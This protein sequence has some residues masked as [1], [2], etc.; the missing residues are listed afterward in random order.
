MVPFVL[1]GLKHTTHSHS[2]RS[3]LFLKGLYLFLNLILSSSCV[4]HQLRL[5]I[6]AVSRPLHRHSDAREF[7]RSEEKKLRRHHSGEASC[8]QY[9]ARA[10]DFLLLLTLHTFHS[11]CIVIGFVT[12]E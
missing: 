4:A 5:L 8:N 6:G 7:D 12:N 2:S 3:N 9:C 1:A 10:P 11:L